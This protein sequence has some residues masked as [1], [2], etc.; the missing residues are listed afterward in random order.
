MN[1]RVVFFY[2]LVFFSCFWLVNSSSVCD[3]MEGLC[4]AKCCPNGNSHNC[5]FKFSCSSSNQEVSHCRFQLSN[6]RNCTCSVSYAD[7][8]VTCSHAS[9][10]S[11]SLL[12]VGFLFSFFF[13][14]V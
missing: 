2:V 6:H 4:S 5:L 13:L 14:G 3:R 8:N 10:L 9:Y 7:R 1:T 12:L 11:P